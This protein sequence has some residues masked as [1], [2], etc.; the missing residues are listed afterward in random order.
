MPVFLAKLLKSLLQVGRNT[1]FVNIRHLGR[2][3]FGCWGIASRLILS[4]LYTQGSQ[5]GLRFLL[6]AP[7]VRIAPGTGRASIRL[8]SAKSSAL[9]ESYRLPAHGDDYH[10]EGDVPLYL[11]VVLMGHVKPMLRQDVLASE[12]QALNIRPGSHLDIGS[13][14]RRKE[15]WFEERQRRGWDSDLLS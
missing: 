10:E 14:T 6:Q 11:S 4:R 8:A 1:I 3:L 7:D 13:R 12:H 15:L 9:G 5:V 2:G